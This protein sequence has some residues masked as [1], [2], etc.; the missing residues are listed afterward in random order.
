MTPTTTDQSVDDFSNWM[1]SRS[2]G[3]SLW[4]NYTCQTYLLKYL[5]KIYNQKNRVRTVFNEL[6]HDLQDA[7]DLD[8]LHALIQRLKQQIG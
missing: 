6:R 5:G 7:D 8:M 4:S 2:K 3:E 1:C